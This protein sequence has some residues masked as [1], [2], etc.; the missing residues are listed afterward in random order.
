[1]IRALAI[2]FSFL[3]PW[4]A[5]AQSKEK[6]YPRPKKPATFTVIK[7][8]EPVA[9]IGNYCGT[10]DIHKAEL[11]KEDSL[12]IKYCF[13]L[14]S[15]FRVLKYKFS[16][17]IGGQYV[18]Y[19]VKGCL[20]TPEIKAALNKT[21]NGDKIKFSGIFAGS[22]DNINKR[23]DDLIIKVLEKKDT[24]LLTYKLNHKIPEPAL[25]SMK[26]Q[27]PD[28]VTRLELMFVEQLLVKC[29]CLIPSLSSRFQVLSFN[30]K[31][32]LNGYKMIFSAR[33]SDI[34]EEMRMALTHAKTGTKI[35]I[36]K[37]RVKT[38]S[39]V[40]GYLSPRAFKVINP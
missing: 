16:G 10:T 21:V 38:D 12:K 19:S 7:M 39:G 13:N 37:I 20:L 31:T 34:T 32:Y 30:L 35:Y 15:E 3:T 1:M 5:C 33:G 18:S 14:P 29:D 40:V 17:Y 4:T 22:R 25:F 24:S 23:Y 6:K 26:N 11:L 27:L 8:G 36:E 9:Y 28:M 2:F